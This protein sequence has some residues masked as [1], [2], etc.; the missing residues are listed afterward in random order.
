MNLVCNETGSRWVRKE[1]LMRCRRDLR[2]VQRAAVESDTMSRV[3][4][5]KLTRQ[6]QSNVVS[7]AEIKSRIRA[8][9][10]WA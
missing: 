5:F 3:F 10:C 8:V 2:Q 7:L 4:F 9:I 1:R 6:V